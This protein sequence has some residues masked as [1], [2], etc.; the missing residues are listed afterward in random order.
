MA[1]I[2]AFAI[3]AILIISPLIFFAGP[4]GPSGVTPRKL[5]AFKP[6]IICFIPKISF[7]KFFIFI[8]ISQGIGLIN[9]RKVFREIVILENA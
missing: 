3:L 9:K 1:T 6:F 7:K 2:L 5:P 8:F 4:R